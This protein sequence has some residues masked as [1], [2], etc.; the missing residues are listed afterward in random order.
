LPALPERVVVGAN[1]DLTEAALETT[2]TRAVRFYSTIQADDGHWPG[3][4][5]GP[6]FLLPGLVITLYVTGA[7]DEILPE[8]YKKE[9]RRYLLNHQNEDGGWGLHF[10]GHSTMFGSVL[11]YVTLR[12]LGDGGEF[13]IEYQNT[14]EKGRDWI[15]LNGGATGI[16]SWGKFW[17]SV[18]GVFEWTGNN[19]LPPEMWLL[20]EKLPVF[21]GRY[22]CHCRMVYLPMSYI[23]GKRFTGEL[24]SLV[25]DLRKEIFCQK[26]SNIDWN[27]ARNQCCKVP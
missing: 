19:P 5:G 21:P 20:P 26:Y 14:L 12:I 24:T 25:K 10:E 2:L 9:M 1:E 11:S 3:D 16:T 13:D 17:L 22:W 23:Y 7:L 15:L 8:P 18:L 27:R 6:M 4:Y